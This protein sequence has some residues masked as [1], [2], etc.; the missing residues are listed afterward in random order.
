VPLPLVQLGGTIGIEPRAAV[1]GAHQIVITFS[2]PVSV[3]GAFVT[4]GAGNASFSVAGSV[5]T[6]TLTGVSNLQR[7]GLTLSNVGEGANLGSIMIPVGFLLGDTSGNGS[8]NA[9]DVAQTKSQAGSALTTSNFRADVNS[10]GSINATDIAQVKSV[11]GS[12]LP[13]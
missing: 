13:P 2:S 8:V 1:S 4:A 7:V 5:V 9:T 10:N 11:A 6:V 3:G 12:Q